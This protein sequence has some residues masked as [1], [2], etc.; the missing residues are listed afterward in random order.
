MSEN[1]AVNYEELPAGRELD[2]LVAERLFKW[3]WFNV[4]GVAVLV[5]PRV[6]E[7]WLQRPSLYTPI[8]GSNGLE[9]EHIDCVRF[10][11]S[12][13]GGNQILEFPHFSTD[14][15]AAWL[16]VEELHRRQ[17]AVEI[18][19]AYWN[20]PYVKIRTMAETVGDAVTETVPLAICRAA[21]RLLSKAEV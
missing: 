19:Y 9:R 2:A 1:K 4:V 17:L 16:V 8:D 5:P 21:L 14:I 10:H 3:R 12:S 20:S 11:D 6:E 7:D 15:A 13:K 18:H